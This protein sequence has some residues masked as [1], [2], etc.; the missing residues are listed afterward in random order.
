METTP[1]VLSETSPD[2]LLI[3]VLILLLVPLVLPIRSSKITP[4]NSVLILIK[5]LVINASPLHN[6]LTTPLRSPVLIVQFVSK[7]P[8]ALSIKDTLFVITPIPDLIRKL[9]LLIRKLL[10]VPSMKDRCVCSVD[11]V[12][13]SLMVPQRLV[14]PQLIPT[15]FTSY[16]LIVYI[17]RKL[18]LLLLIQLKFRVIQEPTMV[19]HF[20]WFYLLMRVLTNLAQ[21]CTIVL[22]WKLHIIM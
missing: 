18:M 11:L 10:I 13:I 3:V 9:E 6:S 19:L 4:W 16:L 1:H 2:V 12:S 22:K 8:M 21:F 14:P 5:P 15:S 20:V 7:E 17:K